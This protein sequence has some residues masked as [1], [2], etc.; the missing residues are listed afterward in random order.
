MFTTP[1]RT[2][3]PSAGRNLNE[4]V[5]G[6]KKGAKDPLQA[7]SYTPIHKRGLAAA[8]KHIH[9]L[10]LTN[11]ALPSGE[12][13]QQ[14]FDTALAHVRD[15]SNLSLQTPVKQNFELIVSSVGHI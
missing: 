15:N 11:D 12:K 7:T 8:K 5:T 1:S 2:T 10:L 3:T 13:M 4:K 6:L 14:F 9:L